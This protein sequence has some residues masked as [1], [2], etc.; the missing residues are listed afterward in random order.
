[1]HAPGTCEKDGVEACRAAGGGSSQCRCGPSRLSSPRAVYRAHPPC[2]EGPRPHLIGN[3]CITLTTVNPTVLVRQPNHKHFNT[4]GMFAYY[5]PVRGTFHYPPGVP[6]P[7]A[8]PPSPHSAGGPP[9]PGPASAGPAPP[10]HSPNPYGIPI[11]FGPP[12]PMQAPV[13]H[14]HYPP[15]H[16]VHAWP[17]PYGFIP[18][19]PPP[20][21][22]G[23]MAQFQQEQEEGLGPHPP[24]P[25]AQQ[26]QAPEGHKTVRLH[27]QP[28]LRRKTSEER[29]AELEAERVRL[30]ARRSEREQ[31]AIIKTEQ[32]AHRVGE[33]AAVIGRQRERERARHAALATLQ[34]HER[35][36]QRRMAA[37]AEAELEAQ[38]AEEHEE[39]ELGQG[40]ID[41]P[42]LLGSLFGLFLED[43]EGAKGKE[44][45][46]PAPAPPAPTPAA[47]AVVVTP[48]AAASP[49]Q[50]PVPAVTVAEATTTTGPAPDVALHHLQLLLATYERLARS[51][52]FP[53][54]LAFDTDPASTTATATSKLHPQLAFAPQNAPVH[55]YE[56]ALNQL[57]A[58]L[59][60]IPSSGDV[61]V[62]KARKELVK[63]VERELA[64]L[65]EEVERAWKREQEEEEDVP[66]E[67][68]PVEDVEEAPLQGENGP[69]T[70]E[71]L[72]ETKAALDAFLAQDQTV[73]LMPNIV[74]LE[75]E[76][77]IAAAEAEESG[78]ATSILHAGPPAV[79]AIVAPADEQSQDEQVIVDRKKA[80]EEASTM[81]EE[82]QMNAP[83]NYEF[84]EP[85]TSSP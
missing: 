19:M 12:P 27:R 78:T 17:Y 5:D 37:E 32:E 45:S 84:V 28:T 1:M 73:E 16:P 57:L 82:V 8:H 65:E 10:A 55:S 7:G 79:V 2:Q 47:P 21:A 85:H 44:Q 76:A 15:P 53:R 13:G 51:F 38:G 24:P 36:R 9:P 54:V 64:W 67:P 49:A 60:E 46:K 42:T 68:L 6:V 56:Q 14:P 77:L 48:K 26:L 23:L 75:A 59:D 43:T 25:Q 83:E 69:A 58:E 41:W 81:E 34:A 62:R 29:L 40:R 74:A 22:Q 20:A 80:E 35:E 30:L 66:E 71:E 61:Q 4:L 52:A 70:E 3:V 33:E 18:G 72:A 50:E 63:K 39:H 11:V 31:R